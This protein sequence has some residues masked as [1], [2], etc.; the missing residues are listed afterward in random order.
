[1]WAESFPSIVSQHAPMGFLGDPG[2]YELEFSKAESG[3]SRWL[4]PWANVGA[5]RFWEYYLGT[6]ARYD[7]AWKNLVPLYRPSQARVKPLSQPLS[8]ITVEGFYYPHGVAGLITIVVKQDLD[9]YDVVD[10]SVQARCSGKYSATWPDG[11]TEQID[12]RELASHTLERLRTEVMGQGKT[13]Q[14]HSGDPF[15]VV[16]AVDGQVDDRDLEAQPPQ[17]GE[18]HRA[19]EALCEWHPL[20][21]ERHPHALDEK[22]SFKF[23]AK[24]QSPSSHILYGLSRGRAVWFP[25]Y[26]TRTG[27]PEI[28]KLGGY[29]RNLTLASLQTES[30]LAMMTIVSGYLNRLEPLPPNLEKLARGAAG[31]LGRLYG[32]TNPTYRSWSSYRQIADSGLTGIIEKARDYLGM[33]PSKL[34]T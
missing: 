15:T 1:M 30:L 23:K 33:K 8:R 34:C 17:N 3:E 10:M 32:A 7:T 14:A 5:R 9:L 16:T 18:V 22:T 19:M 29:H 21:R 24:D 26:F 31:A 25:G 6:G 13:P 27:R 4:L 20:W 2:R 28:R 11:A 12:L